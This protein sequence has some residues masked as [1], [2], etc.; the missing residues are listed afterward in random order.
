VVYQQF[1]YEIGFW[2]Q[3]SAEHLL[4]SVLC[5]SGCFAMIRWDALFAS[6]KEK[7]ECYEADSV[8][9]Q[10]AQ[11]IRGADD[12]V[13][14]DQGEDRFLT[15]LLIS[16]GWLVQYESS[17]VALTYCPSD[18][19]VFSFL[20]HEVSRFHLLIHFSNRNSSTKGDA[21]SHQRMLTC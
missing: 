14:M 4:G 20:F 15:Y 9:L 18:F 5:A 17:A 7:V 19:K 8:A 1:E 6:N 21:G 12:A 10:Y 11:R 13:L 3:K 16:K 2:F